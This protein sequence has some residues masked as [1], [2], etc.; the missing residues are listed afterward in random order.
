MSLKIDQDHS[1]FRAIVRGKIRQNLRKYISQ[2]ELV[3]RKGKDL[4]SIP[5]PQIDIP[6]FR[7]AT[8]NG[9]GP[10][11]ATEMPGDPVGAGQDGDEPGEREEGRTVGGRPRA[12]G[13]RHSRRA[14]VDPGRGARAPRHSRQGQEQDHQR[15]RPV[16]RHPERRPRVASTLQAHLPRGS[17]A[18][19]R[20]GH[21]SAGQSDRGP[22][23]GRQAL[24][25]LEDGGGARGQC[26]HHLHDGRLGLD[27]R[28]AER[29]RAHRE[30]LDRCLAPKRSTKGWRAATS[31]TTPS[32]ARSTARHVLSH[33]RERADDDLER[34]QALLAAHRRSLPARRVE[35]LPV[36]F[37]RRRQLVDGR[38]ASRA[39]TS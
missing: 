19:N 10:A 1:R 13:R 5:I 34:L 18:A 12:R 2:G 7:S 16:H 6:R 14:R 11:R 27:G 15:E 24:P 4:V 28:R 21:V 32:R 29:D 30:L 3:G 33:P 31:S 22:D 9:A 23:S 35:H 8:G 38:H 17:Q 25:E 37:L 26:R 39:S 36:P 20:D